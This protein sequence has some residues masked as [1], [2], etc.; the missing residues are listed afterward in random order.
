MLTL[1]VHNAILRLLKV[2]I[3]NVEGKI[4]MELHEVPQNEN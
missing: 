3:V 1:V 2:N 4:V